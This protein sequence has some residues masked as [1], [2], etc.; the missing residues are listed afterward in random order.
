MTTLTEVKET[1]F[2]VSNISLVLL[3]LNIPLL[4]GLLKLKKKNQC[5]ILFSQARR[6]VFPPQSLSLHTCQTTALQGKGNGLGN[7]LFLCL[8]LCVEIPFLPFFCFRC[9]ISFLL[10]NKKVSIK[11]P[12]L[13]NILLFV[14][15]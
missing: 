5:N 11:L 10:L 1:E 4:V 3:Y 12:H 9:I 14:S 2:I 6:N 7:K 15:D 13:I 8:W